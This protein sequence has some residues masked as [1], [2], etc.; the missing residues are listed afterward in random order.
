M[1]TVN[2]IV[3]GVGL[4]ALVVAGVVV[5]RSVGQQRRRRDEDQQGR[6]DQSP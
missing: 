6:P 1:L 2:M 3:L 5:A 4:A